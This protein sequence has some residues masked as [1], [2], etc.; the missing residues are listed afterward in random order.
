M[1]YAPVGQNVRYR[2]Q[3]YAGGLAMSRFAPLGLFPAL[4]AQDRSSLSL[5]DSRSRRSVSIRSVEYEASLM[6]KKTT[7]AN[8]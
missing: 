7:K 2:R 4:L 1:G 3:A 6:V 5:G 8:I